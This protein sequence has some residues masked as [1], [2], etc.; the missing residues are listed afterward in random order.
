MKKVRKEVYDSAVAHIA[1]WIVDVQYRGID[2]YANALIVAE[3]MARKAI[4]KLNEE[5]RATL[6]AELVNCEDRLP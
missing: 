1:N 3:L 2:D 4:A 6:G 5:D